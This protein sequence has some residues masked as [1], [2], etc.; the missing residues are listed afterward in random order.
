MTNKDSE[1]G[2]MFTGNRDLVLVII[3]NE[4]TGPE[5]FQT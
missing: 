3:F 4:D 2:E 5:D 1:E